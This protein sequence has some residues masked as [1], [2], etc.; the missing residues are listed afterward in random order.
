MQSR[1][2]NLDL[3]LKTLHFRLFFPIFVLGFI[4]WNRVAHT[5]LCALKPSKHPYQMKDRIR[6]LMLDKAM[7]QKSFAAEL[8]IAE[9]TLSGIFNG[10]T[11]PTNQ[12]VSAIHEC[13]P[14]VNVMWLMFGGGDMHTS[15]VP[16]ADTPDAP[17]EGDA[18][19]EE[20]PEQFSSMN[21]PQ[22]VFD[23]PAMHQDRAAFGEHAMPGSHPSAHISPAQVMQPQVQYIEK[24]IDKPQ[25]KITEIRIFFDDGTYETFTP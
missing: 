17:Q 15:Q 21:A 8:C 20:A 10:R 11:R 25:R 16:S 14:E 12:T 22:A 9:A 2:T 23:A 7:S 6:Q 4:K 1:Y 5:P 18:N 19:G 24:Y 3:R 13:F